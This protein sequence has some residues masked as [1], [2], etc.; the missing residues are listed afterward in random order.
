MPISSTCC[1][2]LDLKG[3]M[4]QNDGRCCGDVF[5]HCLCHYS[6]SVFS[7]VWLLFL[8]TW[9]SCVQHMW[10]EVIIN[11]TIH[12]FLWQQS[13]FVSHKSMCV[14]LHISHEPCRCFPLCSATLWH[15]HTQ[16]FASLQVINSV[17]N[18]LILHNW[19]LTAHVKDIQWLYI[20]SD[21]H[22][23]NPTVSIQLVF[24]HFWCRVL[25]WRITW[26]HCCRV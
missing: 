2:H 6:S 24:I 10:W 16:T 1:L 8:E 19:Q 12:R 5:I 11:T 25:P 7:P 17:I 22:E 3:R 20:Q 9:T 13:F 21:I 23:K 4:F 18:S 15:W 26:E 14:T